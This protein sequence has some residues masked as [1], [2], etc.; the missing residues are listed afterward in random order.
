MPAIRSSRDTDTQF[1]ARRKLAACRRRPSGH[2]FFRECRPSQ[3]RDASAE[4]SRQLSQRH[5]ALM[6]EALT[7]RR[8]Y[9]VFPAGACLVLC[10]LLGFVL[11]LCLA[12]LGALGTL[13]LLAF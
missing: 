2:D 11:W 10:A 7:V 13:L 12:A 5:A 8:W 1:S 6:N 9:R 4:G 3:H